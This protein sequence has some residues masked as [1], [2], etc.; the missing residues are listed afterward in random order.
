MLDGVEQL[1]ALQQEQVE[2]AEINVAPDEVGRCTLL[3]WFATKVTG[4]PNAGAKHRAGIWLLQAECAPAVI[5][6]CLQVSAAEISVYRRILKGDPAVREAFSIGSISWKA[7]RA[8]SRVED[9][10]RRREMLDAACQGAS[11]AKLERMVKGDPPVEPSVVFSD[12]GISIKPYCGVGPRERIPDPDPDWLPP[13]DLVTVFGQVMA[14][15]S[16]SRPNVLLT[17]PAGSGKS[18]AVVQMAARLSAPLY[19]VNCSADTRGFNLLGSKGLHAGTTRFEN[20]PV[21]E[22]YRRGAWLLLDEI[23]AASPGVLQGLHTLLEQGPRFQREDGTLVERGEGFQVF[24]TSNVVGASAQ[25][26]QQYG[27]NHVMNMATL[28]R[29]AI[30]LTVE[31]PESSTLVSM[32]K[33]WCLGSRREDPMRDAPAIARWFTD[34]Y[35]AGAHSESRLRYRPALRELKALWALYHTPVSDAQGNLEFKGVRELAEVTV[36]PA[37]TAGEVRDSARELL[38]A[39]VA[40]E[41]I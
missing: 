24:A 16:Q 30:K 38:H 22:A 27:G 5:R 15:P 20:G 37:F 10:A 23:T 40:S 12:I 36:L 14:M 8:L 2:L 19:V 3:P 13:R 29:F 31:P 28:S 18:Q 1:Q 39:L 33:Q 9:P 35:R 41:A 7:V 25:Q 21:L 17:G 4:R 6:A 34:L 32:L 11:G 26:R